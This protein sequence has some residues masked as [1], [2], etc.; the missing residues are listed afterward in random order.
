MVEARVMH[1][2]GP[3]AP[4]P[5]CRAQV[6][7]KSVRPRTGRYL[8][9]AFLQNHLEEEYG[10]HDTADNHRCAAAPRRRLVRPRALVLVSLPTV[11][12]RSSH[13]RS[14]KPSAQSSKGCASWLSAVSRIGSY[15]ALVN[16]PECG[17]TDV[18]LT[19]PQSKH[20]YV[21]SSLSGWVG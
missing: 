8:F 17:R 15:A 4:P 14:V 2:V 11:S 13:W 19:G 16:L 5:N 1:S 12:E 6:S 9:G 7:R 21:W 3:V 20:R 10:Y 18:V